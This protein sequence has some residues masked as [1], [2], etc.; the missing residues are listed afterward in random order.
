MFCCYFVM[1]QRTVL[2]HLHLCFLDNCKS[3]TQLHN[4]SQIVKEPRCILERIPLRNFS[5]IC[6]GSRSQWKRCTIALARTHTCYII[7]RRVVCG[8][9]KTLYGVLL[10]LLFIDSF[11]T[12]LITIFTVFNFFLLLFFHEAMLSFK[13]FC[14]LNM[15]MRGYN[16]N[17]NKIASKST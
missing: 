13:C 17:K 9:R 5:N 16:F 14:Y 6:L 2:G 3:R 10:H 15:L 1:L 12:F 8:I 11:S 4:Y 7:N